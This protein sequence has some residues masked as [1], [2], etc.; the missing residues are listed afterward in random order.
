MDN[1]KGN[2]RYRTIVAGLFDRNSKAFG[3][4]RAK[5]RS[6]P[7]NVADWSASGHSAPIRRRPACSRRGRRTRCCTRR[8]ASGAL[9]M[10]SDGHCSGQVEFKGFSLSITV[11]DAATADRFFNALGEGGQVQVPLGKPSS[12]GASEWWLTGSAWAGWSSS[13]PD[14]FLRDGR[15]AQPPGLS[16]LRAPRP[17][18]EPFRAG[19]RGS[20]RRE[21]S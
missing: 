20:H 3:P 11:P 4:T 6:K 15:G 2:A 14:P 8:C 18:G 9:V 7:L 12:R 16:A 5:R 21:S 10:A 1:V 13:P 19:S 17:M